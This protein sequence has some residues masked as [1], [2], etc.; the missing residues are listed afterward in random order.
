MKFILGTCYR[1]ICFSFWILFSFGFAFLYCNH[2]SV[3]FMFFFFVFKVD[4][5]ESIY[6]ISNCFFCK[7]ISSSPYISL[8]LCLYRYFASETREQLF[9][10]DI[11]FS[12]FEGFFCFVFFFV[13]SVGILEGALER[14]N[15]A[16]LFQ[17][18]PLFIYVLVAIEFRSCCNWDIEYFL[19]VLFL[20]FM[21]RWIWQAFIYAT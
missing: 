8:Y 7:Y 1:F 16:N 3:F 14:V 9:I 18:L 15:Y 19:G 20:Q 13:S 4:L 12:K 11:G 17:Y 2:V 5:K 6:L 10:W 21:F